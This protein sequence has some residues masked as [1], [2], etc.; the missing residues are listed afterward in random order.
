ML[1]ILA[2]VG[3]SVGSA[4]KK[5]AEAIQ[6]QG[7]AQQPATNPTSEFVEAARQANLERQQAAAMQMQ[8]TPT[9]LAGV[10]PQ[11]QQPQGI[12][13]SGGSPGGMRAGMLSPGQ[14][15]PAL[16]AAMFNSRGF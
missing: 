12:L 9:A 10:Q 6:A 13:S 7:G 3:A 14:P 11:A 2:A 8:T 5:N 1:P 15:D 4:A 16:L